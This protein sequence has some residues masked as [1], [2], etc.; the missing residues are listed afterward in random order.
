LHI[1]TGSLT[2]E[3]KVENIARE[4]ELD[5]IYVVRTSVP[6]ERLSTPD[7]VRAYKRLGDVEKAFRTFKGLDL[8]VRP[9][10]HR[11]DSR[12][13]AHLFLCMLAYYIE[14]HM[15]MVLAPLLY[16]DEDLEAVRATCD[17]VALAE[18]S[19]KSMAKRRAKNRGW[20]AITTLG[21]TASGVDDDHKKLSVKY[22]RL[23]S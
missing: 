21:R 1:A 10:H 12:V 11:L 15:R 5:G 3:R 17:P 20:L 2:W 19:A 22:G 14:W 4:K 16:A 9:I 7:V 18:P 23:S 13:R 6:A 8:R